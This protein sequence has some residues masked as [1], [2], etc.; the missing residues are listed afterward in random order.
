MAIKFVTFFNRLTDMMVSL[1]E[2][3][4]YLSEYAKSSRES[5][6][7]R[8]VNCPINQFNFFHRT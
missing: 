2:H 6:L 1:S 5:G 3:L 4:E 7:I 8:K